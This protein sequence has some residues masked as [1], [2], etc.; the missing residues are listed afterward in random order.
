MKISGW[1]IVDLGAESTRPGATS[2]SSDEEWERLKPFLERFFDLFDEKRLR[3][4]ISVDTPPCLKTAESQS[5]IRSG[6]Y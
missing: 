4:L 6:H 3:P 1:S 2:L 5:E